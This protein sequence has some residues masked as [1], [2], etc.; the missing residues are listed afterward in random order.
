MTKLQLPRL[1]RFLQLALAALLLTQS[2]VF[3][4]TDQGR[5]VGLV[6]DSNGALV[7]GAA[8]VVR[9]ER[10]GEER[11]ATT[12]DDG[13]FVVPALKASSYVVTATA[14]D[15]APAEVAGVQVAVG[16]ERNLNITLT[17]T[18]LTASVNIVA[19]A[20][21]V[22]DTSSASMSATVN[23]R[24]VEGLPING[25]QLSQ[26][27]LQAPGSVNS[28]SGTFGDIRFSGR[29]V[30][31]NI[32]RFDGIEGSAII[33][34]SPGNL[35]GEVPSPFRLQSSLENVQEF[36]VD[37]NNF[38]A[39]YGTGTGG[40][41]NVV[42]KSGGNQFHGSVFEFLRNDAL[43]AANFFDNIIGKKSPLRLNQFGGSV[44]GPIVK[45]KLF[46]FVSYEGYRLRAG[47]NSIEAVPGTAAR[48]CAAPFGIGTV[49]CNAAIVP[50]L[51]AFRSPLASIIQ[52]GTGS[53]L[54]DVAQ[55]QANSIVD[56][57][58]I[59]ARFD[60][61]LN[62]RHS[63][64]LRYFRDQG[65]NDQP[66]GVTGRRVL[67]KANPQN[68]V[69]AL[70]SI[71]RPTVLNEFKFG[72]N[73]AYTRINGF[74]PTLN[75]IDLSSIAINISGNTANFGIAGQGT[76]A[77]TAVPGGL[78]RANSAT[79][80]RGQPYTPYS[81]SFV[82]NLNWT[83][84]P[85]NYKFGGEVR[86]IR[87]Y[88][89]RL[90]GTTY[91]YSNITSF[92]A[93]TPQSVQFLGDVSAPSPFNDGATGQRLAKQEYYIAFAQD[94]WKI[95]PN[96]TLNYGL[97]YEYYTPLREA[98]D[99]QV[100][101]DTRTGRLRPSSEDAFK[102]RKTNFG[103]RVALTWS[104]NQNG[105]GFFSGGRTTL[106]SGFGIYYGPSQTEDQIQPIESDRISSTFT[107]GPLNIFPLDTSAAIAFF[108]ANPNTR[109]YQPRAYAREYE[110]PEKVYQY[111]VS[112]QQEL[113]YN[114]VGTIAYV[115]SQGRDLF[116]RSIANK[117]L[118]GQTSIVNGT[119][120]PAHVGVV[121]RTDPATG[122]VIGVTTVREFSIVNGAS[123]QNPFAEVDYKTTGGTD[124]YNALQATLSRRFDTGLTL[125]AQYTFA[126][127]YGNT[128]GSN[129][130]RTLA[131]N[132]NFEDDRGY[133][134]F[135]V[136]HTFNLSAIYN[137]PFGRGRRYDLGPVGNAILGN[138]E[139]GGIV[140]AR[141]G[142]PIEV[143]VTRP[144]VVIQ[145][146]NASGCAVPTGA[147]TSA[148]LPNGFVAALPGT[149]N[150]SNPLPQGFVA[151]VNTPGGGASRNVRRPDLIPGVNPYLDDDRA[152][153][154][155]AAFSIPEAGAFGDLARNALRGPNFKQFDLIL[156]K[157][158][159]L[160]ETINVEF[161]TEVFNIL[162]T[163]NFA[164]PSSTLNNA[165][166]SIS[167]N[168]TTG[169]YTV[170]SGRQPGQPFTQSAA[171]STFGL[172]RQTVERTVG[173]GTNRQI[174]FALRLNF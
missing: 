100:L 73:G 69:V 99:L 23:Q 35:N 87:L 43:D 17:T 164:N 19:G 139:I 96:L 64:Y 74:A 89:D 168:S 141:S 144:D 10:T 54:F 145:C 156:N 58:A 71:L 33:D 2:A 51:P 66:E 82:D 114:T 62:A 125:N 56:E 138:W 41:I 173:L 154:N 115:G 18:E 98:R 142:L 140:N 27:Y 159:Q 34:A 15:F 165:L 106:R 158:F 130:A 170:G 70:Q 128:A 108:N 7:S 78:V 79:N 135:D 166:P 36:R 77:G 81:L 14:P 163:A 37:S 148:T 67:I 102:S 48:I 119:N 4:Q 112:M 92:L 90:G 50:L 136:R 174:Q 20:E 147:G 11:T 61:K 85:H 149:I 116:L 172:L 40:Q 1:P 95:R 29:A 126:R 26:L 38:P 22:T 137:L 59:A 122:R 157:R 24:E 123:V 101:F 68:G 161:R 107:S 57:N 171:G 13:T 134:N 52:Q 31:Q 86:L 121:N 111:S 55:L 49:N 8:V 83:R 104:P 91:T 146:V 16:Q 97:R 117:I 105:T 155:P 46:F 118:P 93:N 6:A 76:S 32:I 113:F 21:A 47:V 167:F 120:I 30:Q 127:S 129:E 153:L 63:L 42:T 160:T 152:I 132:F 131:T 25:R 150:A 110:I 39:E 65:T 75:G 94:E 53:N 9:N 60:Y 84:G 169:F 124:S 80:G 151:V 5:I 28:G 3:A 162:N 88:T 109:S 12:N 72:F 133:N 44:G 143:L 103:P 45:D